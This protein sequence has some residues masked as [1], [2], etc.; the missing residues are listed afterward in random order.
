M[1]GR[2]WGL[3][4]E[5]I[6]SGYC[7]PTTFIH[8]VWRFEGHQKHSNFGCSEVVHWKVLAHYCGVNFTQKV[9]REKS[10]RMIIY[11]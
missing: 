11:I 10:F 4:M 1:C 3:E 8:I 9:L 5:W 2:D 6:R 7:R